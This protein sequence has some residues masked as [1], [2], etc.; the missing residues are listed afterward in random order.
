MRRDI[1]SL[2]KVGSVIL[3]V[4]VIIGY[5]YFRTRDVVRGVRIEVTTVTDGMT[6]GDPYLEVAGRAKNATTLVINGRTVGVDQE[7][8]FREP[9]ILLPGYTI[10][11][12]EASDKFG[13]QVKKQYRV[14]LKDDTPTTVLTPEEEPTI[15]ESAEPEAVDEET[16]S[17]VETVETINN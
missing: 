2:L 10:I 7:G 5:A 13:K 1:A 17:E 3:L 14:V 16:A 15:E 11:T 6:V 12:L 8:H 9:L 4:L